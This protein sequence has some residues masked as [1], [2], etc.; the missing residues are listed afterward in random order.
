MVTHEAEN[1]TLRQALKDLAEH[2]GNEEPTSTVVE[3]FQILEDEQRELRAEV[4]RLQGIE[5]AH[6]GCD[7]I[8]QKDNAYLISRAEAAEAKVARV[9][10]L[11]VKVFTSVSDEVYGNNPTCACGHHW[12]CETRAALDGA[13]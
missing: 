8:R 7:F 10:E 11:H 5:F 4:K 3:A 9:E 1:A 6:N 13:E 2:R 12:P